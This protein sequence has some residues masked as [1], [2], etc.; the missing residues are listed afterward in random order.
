MALQAIKSYKIGL[1]GGF[2]ISWISV[3]NLKIRLL[4]ISGLILRKNKRFDDHGKYLPA[5]QGRD[6]VDPVLVIRG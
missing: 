3:L 4:P 5:H 6:D 1:M 2:F